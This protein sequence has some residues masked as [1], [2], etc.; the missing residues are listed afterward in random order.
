MVVFEKSLEYLNPELVEE[1]DFERNS[2]SPKEVNATS[3]VYYWWKCSMCGYRWKTATYRRH[4]GSGCPICS[5]IKTKKGVNDLMSQRPD[6]MKEWDFLKNDKNPDQ[7]SLHANYKAHWK[8]KNGHEW[9]QLVSS[10]VYRN[11]KCPYCSGRILIET[12]N[13][14]FVKRPDIASELYDKSIDA[15]KIKY[16]SKRIMSWECK[17][18]HIWETSVYHR[19][20]NG[21]KCPCCMGKRVV[22]GI[23]DFATLYPELLDEWN[24][25]KNKTNPS[26]VGASSIKLF[27]WKC[28]KGHEWRTS[29]AH[30][31]K[32]K[33]GCPYCAG[34]KVIVGETDLKTKC[35]EIA[36]EYYCEKNRLAIEQIHWGSTK[37]VWWKCTMCGNVWRARV[38]KRT[39]L[40][41]GCPVCSQC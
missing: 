7:I 31:T 12:E 4:Y 6:L 24:Y 1:W 29:I 14:L 15:K 5:R 39:K 30:R 18:G 20:I 3:H 41:T 10:R 22:E 21:S 2:V 34:Q 26:Q 33:S 28:V 13:S 25:E 8:C 35:P 9:E 36:D 19:V 27:H 40:G 11:S 17:E 37:R 23:N 32:D 38:E 16:N